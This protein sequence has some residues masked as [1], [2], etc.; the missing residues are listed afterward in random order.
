MVEHG[1]VGLDGIF[2][3]LSAATHLIG[4]NNVQPT[5]ELHK[6]RNAQLNVVCKPRINGR[7]NILNYF[8]LKQ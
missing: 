4:T 5:A 1:I 6:Y 7:H 2:G 8:S 3:D